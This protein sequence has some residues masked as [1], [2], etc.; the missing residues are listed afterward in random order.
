MYTGLFKT[1]HMTEK[2]LSPFVGSKL[3]GFNGS[4]TKPWGYVDLLVTFGEGEGKKTIKIS[5]M[6]IDCSSLYNCIIG[7]T[8][9]AQL[10]VAC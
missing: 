10:R 1:L 4:S 7:M 5:F 2:N 8:G 9:M 6:V 3:S